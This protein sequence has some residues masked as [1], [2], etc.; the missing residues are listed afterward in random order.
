LMYGSQ[1]PRSA[2]EPQTI[3]LEYL[4]PLVLRFILMETNGNTGLPG[5]FRIDNENAGKRIDVLASEL[6][7]ISRS[8]IHHLIERG[9]L[10]VNALSTKPNYKTKSGDTISINV[11]V[12]EQR[13]IKENLF[14]E[15]L[16]HDDYLIVVNKP[17]GMVVYPGAGH[18]TGTL[19]NAVAYHS[20]KLASIGAP[21]RP[22]VVHRL[23]K[24]TSGVMVIALDDGAYYG[25]V[26]QFRER[27]IDR[28]YKALVYG[29]LREDRGQISLRIG[30]SESDRKKM[31]TRVRR[32][33]EAVTTWNVVE[34]FGAATLIEAKL[35]TGRTHQIRVHFASIGHPVLGD[36]T[37]GRKTQ[38][39][40]GRKK[41]V[42]PR[43]MLHAE[44]L[45]F[46][47]PL[48]GQYMKF[49]SDPP[50]D[51]QQIIETLRELKPSQVR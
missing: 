32:G 49:R 36:M 40:A 13:L 10:T 23:D 41:I 51:M 20:P 22:G 16:F 47:H 39:E 17:A 15:I 19:M 50:E 25:L 14:V 9:F 28:R 21:L 31:S 42:F 44:L 27:T 1:R 46:V 38:V 43:Q 18:G 7:G 12:K 45:G 6:S 8:Q 11:P 37:Y 30:R 2:K 5:E 33:K 35:G 26:E 3:S 24:D 34:R 48:T 29:N 4:R